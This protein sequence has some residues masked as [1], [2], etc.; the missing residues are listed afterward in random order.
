MELI[1]GNYKVNSYILDLFRLDGGA[2]FGSVPKSLWGKEMPADEKNRIQLCTRV[3]VIEGE[4]RKILVDTGCGTCWSDKEKEIFKIEHQYSNLL[5]NLIPNVTDVVLSHLHFDHAGGITSVAN[6]Q[7]VPSFPK[8]RHWV[9]RENLER[10]K[11]PGVRERV[12]YRSSEVDV[13]TQVDL[14]Q[15]ESGEEIIPGIILNNLYGHTFGMSWIGLK[16][17]GV[18]KLIFLADLCP[19]SSHLRIP[20]LMGYDLLAEVTMKEK[21]EVLDIAVNNKSLVVFEH[22]PRVSS[23]YLEKDE[24]GNFVMQAQYDLDGKF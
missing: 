6:G 13:L 7:F 2:M 10:A 15:V 22:G 8:A 23:A 17:Q 9:S 24:R 4:G 5:S 21:Q 11:N 14:N 19:T 20:Y 1:V 16:E 18:Y 3:L 12:S